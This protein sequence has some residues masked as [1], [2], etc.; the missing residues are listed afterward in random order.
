M[1]H[2]LAEAQKYHSASPGLSNEA[3]AAAL[4]FGYAEDASNEM[5]A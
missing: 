3:D 5:I 2:G 4:S 1:Q